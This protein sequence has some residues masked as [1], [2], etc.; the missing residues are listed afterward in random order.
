MS[1]ATGDG[2]EGSSAP[3]Y[4]QLAGALAEARAALV[5]LRAA[6]AERDRVIAGL[7]A[8]VAEQDARIAELSARLK[9]DSSNSSLPPSAEGLRKKPAQPRRSGGRR[10]KRP[11]SPGSHLAM[12]ADP[13]ETIDHVPQTCQGCGSGLG[14][15]QVV[16]VA[17]RQVFDLPPIRLRV[18][19]HRAQRRR[20]GC[21]GTVTAAGLPAAA[22]APACYGPQ[23]R[24]LIAYLAVGQHLP[25]GRL[26]DVLAD[27]LGAPVAT[28]TV[29]AV[30]A[31]AADAVA[32]AVEAIRRQLA[33]APVAHFDETGARIDGRLGWLHSASTDRLTL[34]HA[35]AR[36]GT[37]AMDAA[38][39]LPDFAGVAVHDGWIP[40]RRYTGIEHALCNAHHLRELT[41]AAEAGH[42]WAAHLAGLLR[43]AHRWVTDAKAAGK[44]ALDADL[45]VS[46]HARYDGHLAQAIHDTAG[47]KST[48]AALGRRLV[49]HRDDV[50]RFT[51]DFAVPFDNNQAERDI[52][53]VKLQQKISGCW[54]TLPGAQAFCAIR[55]YLTTTRKHGQPTL[56]ALRQA[57]LIG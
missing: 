15:A 35:D 41:A 43:Q 54:R 23:V 50:L 8:R 6:L 36:R 47:A 19:E 30:L 11:G 37:T 7:R 51:T 20:C 57:L 45:L 33:A 55:S 52:R 48:A 49:R 14:A 18:V 12:V 21:C 13:D 34:Y 2:P 5:E 22:R 16:G 1:E 24:A 31:E 32:P 3:S 17:R 4:E 40:Y 38:G 42:D 44:A 39:V 25:V 10:G 29:A 28:G 9:A 26:A 27:V 46:V 53:M 56:D